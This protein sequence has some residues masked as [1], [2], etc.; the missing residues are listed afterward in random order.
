MP[1]PKLLEITGQSTTAEQTWA[2]FLQRRQA[3]EAQMQLAVCDGCD[4]CGGRCVAGFG[5]TKQEWQAV[6]AFL[7]TQPEAER[8]RI[9]EQEHTLPWPGAEELSTEGDTLRVTYCRFRDIESG[10]CSIYPARPTICRLFGQV[11]WL[12]C[13]IGAV[14]AYPE[15]A[16]EVWNLYRREKRKTWEE[17]QEEEN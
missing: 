2:L 10:R 15:A 17:W 4:Q 13:P 8:R 7:A 3:L 11:G 6:Q 5:V 12:P 1:A 9:E 14:T 16:P